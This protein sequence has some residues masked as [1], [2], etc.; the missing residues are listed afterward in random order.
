MN[1]RNAEYRYISVCPIAGALGAEI[2]GV[3]LV[4]SLSSEVLSEIRR[5]YLENLVIFT[6][7]QDITPDQ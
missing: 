6:R 2:D 1:H 5:A 7:D 3:N 4:E